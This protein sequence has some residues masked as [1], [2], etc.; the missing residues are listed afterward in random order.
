M[1]LFLGKPDVSGQRFGFVGFKKHSSAA[2]AMDELNRSKDHGSDY[3]L[4]IDWARERQDDTMPD[5][6]DGK[7]VEEPTLEEKLREEKAQAVGL[8]KE[9]Q[10][11]GRGEEF[12][13]YPLWVR[14]KSV[15]V[16][17]TT[18]MSN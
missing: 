7:F 2:K 12:P 11:L 1:S 5:L 17:H 6:F 10:D 18:L 13:S 14:S 15:L 4:R 9:L 8:A 3:R 16:V